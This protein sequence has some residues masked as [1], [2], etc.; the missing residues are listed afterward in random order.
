MID[1]PEKGQWA[2]AT[3]IFT[4][5]PIHVAHLIFDMG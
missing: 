3:L 4:A 1:D 5:N 2:M